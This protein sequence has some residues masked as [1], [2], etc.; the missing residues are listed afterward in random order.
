MCQLPTLRTYRKLLPSQTEMRQMRWCP[1]HP[2]VTERINLKMSDVSSV[3]A[4]HPA[5]YKGCT[6]YK[7]LQQKTCPY[8]R[9]K[10][11]LPPA[12]LLCPMSPS[13]HPWH[14]IHTSRRT[15]L[16]CYF[17]YQSN[18]PPFQQTWDIHD[19]KDMMKQLLE[20]MSTML[21]LLTT[22]V[23]LATRSPH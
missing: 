6:V 3:A 1:L 21:N 18:Y 10:Q 19:L 22:A 23:R 16:T 2:A 5:N 13:Y 11:Y 9:P 8:L 17:I 12:P 4:N 14:N 20:Q 15:Q 7:E